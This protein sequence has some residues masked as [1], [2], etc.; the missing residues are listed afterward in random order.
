MTTIR[1]LEGYRVGGVP[2]H[3]PNVGFYLESFILLHGR[4]LVWHAP[5]CRDHRIP[6]A[7]N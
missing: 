1:I 3:V 5:R 7:T 2:K 4:T 6:E